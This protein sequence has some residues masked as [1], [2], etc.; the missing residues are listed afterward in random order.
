ME[1]V[2]QTPARVV[3]TWLTEF[4]YTQHTCADVLQERGE[5]FVRELEQHGKRL[6]DR[7]TMARPPVGRTGVIR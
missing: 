2:R 1:I 7:A 5:R 3:S 6:A 4:G